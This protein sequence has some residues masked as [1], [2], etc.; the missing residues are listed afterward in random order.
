MKA[1]HLMSI[2][3]T[4][5][6]ASACHDDPMAPAPKPAISAT[7]PRGAV[8]LAILQQPVNTDGSVTF[9]VRVLTNDVVVSSFQGNVT[10][11]PGTLDLVSA[12]TPDSKDGEAYFL[13]AA[14]AAQGRIRFAAFT[15]R[16]FNGTDIDAGLEAFR[17]TVK[18]HVAIELSRLAGT[19]TAVGRETGVRMAADLVLGSSGASDALSYLVAR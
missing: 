12:K 13:N 14:D 4:V 16:A 11:E 3:A 1:R 5:V 10:F 18:P 6:A 7:V 8:Q 15:P 9:V 2:A 17:F 19:F